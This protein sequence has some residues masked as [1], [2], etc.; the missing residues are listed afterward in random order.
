M[1]AVAPVVADAG[2]AIYDQRVDLQLLQPR[3]DAQSG[4][5]AADDEN[6]GIAVGVFGGGFAEVE[7]V[8]AAKIARIGLA[9]RPRYSDLFL[10]PL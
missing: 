4:L 3:R 5:A 7:P 9:T 2:F 10:K 6:G 1:I 8:G